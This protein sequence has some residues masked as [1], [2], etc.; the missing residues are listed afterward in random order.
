MHSLLVAWTFL[1]LFVK[2]ELIASPIGMLLVFS[3]AFLGIRILLRWN[4]DTHL[5]GFSGF[6]YL[7][8][9]RVVYLILVDALV[10]CS[11]GFPWPAWV[12]GTTM[13]VTL[14]IKKASVM[15]RALLS[16]T[17]LLVGAGFGVGQLALDGIVV[18][19][20]GSMIYA[21]TPVSRA[22]RVDD[23]LG[24]HSVAICILTLL[25]SLVYHSPLYE[26]SGTCSKDSIR[27]F[28]WWLVSHRTSSRPCMAMG[29]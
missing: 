28:G 21:L 27:V 2:F 26:A 12:E 20:L 3:F 1:S 11:I 24:A 10:C 13:P 5:S 22:L 6:G 18:V 25:T 17:W 19:W 15:L 8:R 7:R 14:W 23:L 4:F 16:V 29:R 9:F